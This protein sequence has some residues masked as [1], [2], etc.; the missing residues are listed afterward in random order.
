MR[1]RVLGS[2]DRAL[3]RMLVEG[4]R[5]FRGVVRVAKLWAEGQQRD[6]SFGPII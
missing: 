5:G 6:P 2:L 1:G 4:V 3:L